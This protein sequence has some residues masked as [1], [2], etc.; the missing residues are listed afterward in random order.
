MA[1]KQVIVNLLKEPGHLPWNFAATLTMKDVI[2]LDSPVN[3]LK[4]FP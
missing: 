3:N 4:Y 2:S 1:S